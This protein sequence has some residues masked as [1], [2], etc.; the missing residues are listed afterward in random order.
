LI[1]FSCII[2]ILPLGLYLLAGF[3]D[4]ESQKYREDWGG[5]RESTKPYLSPEQIER[6]RQRDTQYPNW[7]Y[8]DRIKL[9]PIQT[10]L[11]I[12]PMI[13]HLPKPKQPTLPPSHPGPAQPYIKLD[14]PKSPFT[15]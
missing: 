7:Y 13:A 9:P 6:Q 8:D 14:G 2:V 1:I 15:E 3:F 4:P 11:P 10:P 5:S 12:P